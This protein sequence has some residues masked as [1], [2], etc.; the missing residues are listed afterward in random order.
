MK[1]QNESMFTTFLDKQK[2]FFDKCGLQ[3][4]FYGHPLMDELLHKK[5]KKLEFEK[6]VPSNRLFYYLSTL[7]D[8]RF[9]DTQKGT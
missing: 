8:Y 2:E 5:E 4:S 1:R 7:T 6:P 3:S 9:H